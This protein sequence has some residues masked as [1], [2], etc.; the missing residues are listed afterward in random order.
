VFGINCTPDNLSLEETTLTE[1]KKGRGAGRGIIP[2][3]SILS[4]K[5]KE[6]RERGGKDFERRK[7]S[8]SEKRGTKFN[9]REEAEG[10]GP[11]ISL[12]STHRGKRGGEK[13]VPG[14]SSPGET[15]LER[16]SR[17]RPWKVSGPQ[18]GKGRRGGPWRFSIPRT[19]RGEILG[20]KE[21]GC[22]IFVVGGKGKK[23]K[24]NSVLLPP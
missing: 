21:K 9:E 15:F 11:L 1:E 5:K 7:Q 13:S 4:I 16:G 10:G 3:L 17:E 24:K 2:T 19:R 6:G 12:Q 23:G 8:R 14:C 22:S 18:G 20:K